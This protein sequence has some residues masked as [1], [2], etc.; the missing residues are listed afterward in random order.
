MKLTNELFNDVI[1]YRMSEPGAMG[2]SGSLAILKKNGESFEFDYLS[3]KT[4]WEEIKR[5]F[6]GINGCRFNGPMIDEKR[7]EGELVIGGF[8]KS[9]TVNPGWKHF[10]LDF[11]NHLVCKEEYYE[12]LEKTFKGFDNIDI[13]FDWIKILNE[14]GFIQDINK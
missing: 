7:G 12:K 6:P 1:A 14:S 13:T 8:G 4:P 11:G 9:T 3:D 2:P 5:C 10:Y